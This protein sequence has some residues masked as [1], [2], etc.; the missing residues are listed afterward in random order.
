MVKVSIEVRSGAARFDVGVQAE[1]IQRA[2]DL[3]KGS[4]SASDVKVVFPID[5]EGFFVADALAAEGLIH[6]SNFQEQKEELAA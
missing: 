3:V 6:R 2:V 1:S 4:Y 5:P